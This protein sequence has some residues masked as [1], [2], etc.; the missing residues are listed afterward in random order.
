MKIPKGIERYI[1]DLL[2]RF[3]CF[4]KEVAKKERTKK[5]D[6]RM[7]EEREVGECL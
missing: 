1:L 2:N 7:A 4:R 3:R 6:W 5:S